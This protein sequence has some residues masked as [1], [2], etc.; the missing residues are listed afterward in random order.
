MTRAFDSE[1]TRELWMKSN[2]KDWRIIKIFIKECIT[3]DGERY[4]LPA[5]V[6]E[7]KKK[8]EIGVFLTV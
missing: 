7:W 3:E 2:E 1:K 8:D 4:Y 6:A 5:V